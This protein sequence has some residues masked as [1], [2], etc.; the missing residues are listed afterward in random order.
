MDE[1]PPLPSMIPDGT[2][3]AHAVREYARQ[4]VYAD[5]SPSLVRAASAVLAMCDSIGEFRNGVT[6]STGTI[7]E[8]SVRA[9]ELLEDLRAA[10][11]QV[12]QAKTP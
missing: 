11:S 4:A 7:D 5:P 3:L 10:L 1:L 9:G 2:P 6:D 12:E 8:G